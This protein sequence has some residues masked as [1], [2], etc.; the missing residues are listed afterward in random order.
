MKTANNTYKGIAFDEPPQYMIDAESVIVPS[1]AGLVPDAAN[2]NLLAINLNV[3]IMVNQVGST[4]PAGTVAYTRP[5]AGTSVP[6]GTQIKVYVSKGGFTKVPSVK[7]MTVSEATNAL[8]S[9]GFPTVSAP[10]PSQTLYFVHDPNV[11]AGSVVGTDPPAGKAVISSSAI[12][13]I[14]SKGP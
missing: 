10:Q 6:I 7:G 5:K 3:K 12:L 4:Q 9:A 1:V 2:Q 8:N 11:A 13:L 14:I